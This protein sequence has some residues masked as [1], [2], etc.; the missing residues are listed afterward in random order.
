[1][2]D[3]YTRAVLTVIAGC[4]VWNCIRDVTNQRAIAQSRPQPQPVYIIGIDLE[5]GYQPGHYNFRFGAN[6]LPTRQ[7]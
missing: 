2:T 5:P 3:R 7:N 4:L 6:T 1:M